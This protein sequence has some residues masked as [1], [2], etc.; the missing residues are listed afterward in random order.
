[1]VEPGGELDLAE[2]APGRHGGG[3]LGIHE[4]ERDRAGVPQ[5]LRQVHGRHAAAPELAL[6]SVAG[7]EGCPEGDEIGRQWSRL[8]WLTQR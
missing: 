7:G 1:M 2:K 8:R 3:E 5:V 6:E 4:L